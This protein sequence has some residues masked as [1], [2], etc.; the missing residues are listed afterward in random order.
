MIYFLNNDG[1]LFITY[2]SLK[3]R[4][5]EVSKRMSPVDRR[6]TVKRNGLVWMEKDRSEDAL[7]M[8]AL[9]GKVVLPALGESSKTSFGTDVG[10]GMMSWGTSHRVWS[11]SVMRT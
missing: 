9:L 4:V 6:E 7:E 2:R 5:A 10:R 3:T 11:A 8:V 1:I